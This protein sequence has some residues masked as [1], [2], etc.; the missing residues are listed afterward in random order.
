MWF[1]FPETK[2]VPLEEM[3]DLFGD[4][5]EVVVRLADVHLDS[6]TLNISTKKQDNPDTT[7]PNE[8]EKRESANFHVESVSS[9]KGH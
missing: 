4:K 7:S 1:Q 3:A 2:G 6:S 5:R 9:I 8:L